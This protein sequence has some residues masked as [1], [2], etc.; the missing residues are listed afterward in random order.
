MTIDRSNDIKMEALTQNPELPML[1]ESLMQLLDLISN[2]ATM[3]EISAAISLDS[4]L[5]AR[6]LELAN[7]AWYK[8]EG[9]IPDVETALPI[10][11]IS[12]LYLII[13]SSSVTRTF[14]GVSSKFINMNSFWKQCV[15][16]AVAAQLLATRNNHPAPMQLFTAGILAYIGK[17]VLF[18]AEPSLAQ[19]IV[20]ACQD[21]RKP[22]FIIEQKLLGF[23]HCDISAELMKKWN[24]P[25]SLSEPVRYYMLPFEAPADIRES[26]SILHIAHNIQ[27]SYVSESDVTDPPEKISSQALALLEIEEQN[28]APMASEMLTKIES[29]ISMLKL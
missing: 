17:L 27:Y 19:K 9:S 22:Q 20:Q 28:L 25:K 16:M 29:T 26:A 11:G 6:T 18:S 24:I 14:D 12:T 3:V 1:P 5:T 10:V 23:S 13:F 21:T 8:R 4:S 2:D 7:S 15:R